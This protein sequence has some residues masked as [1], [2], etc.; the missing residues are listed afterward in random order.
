LSSSLAG[1]LGWIFKMNKWAF[2]T[3]H[4]LVLAAI[5]RHPGMTARH[6][7]DAVGI[8]ERTTHMI[9]NDLEAAGYVTKLK[10]GRRNEYL[11]HPELPLKEEA[12]NDI[13]ASELLALLGW[14]PE[15]S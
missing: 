13:A 6:I 15:K 12:F 4:G 1:N 8:T 7:G 10:I 14:K 2:I 9:I 3:N 5:A 11:V